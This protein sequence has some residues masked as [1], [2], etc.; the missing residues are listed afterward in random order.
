MAYD[1]KCEYGHLTVIRL[2]ISQ[3]HPLYVECEECGAAA[4]RVYYPVQFVVKA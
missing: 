2:A 1:F 4:Y 3:Q